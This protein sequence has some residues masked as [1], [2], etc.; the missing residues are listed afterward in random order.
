MQRSILKIKYILPVTLIFIFLMPGIGFPESFSIKLK[1]PLNIS[2]PNEEIRINSESLKVKKPGFE[3]DSF[4]IYENKKEIP[5][6]KIFSKDR[7]KY[8]IIFI[9]S[10]QP[11]ETKKIIFADNVKGGK[12]KKETQAYL[13]KKVDYILKNGNYS[14][15][16][17]VS[18][19]FTKVPVTHVEHDALYQF[20]GP[21]WESGKIAYR[22][23]LDDRNRTDIFGKKENGLFLNIIGKNDLVSDGNESYQKGM[24]DWGRDIFKVGNSLGIGSIATFYKNKV[25]TVSEVDSITCQIFNGNLISE[26]TTTHYG[27][28]LDKKYNI[29][30][31][32]SIPAKSRNTTVN[33]S[34]D[35]N[36]D[37]FCTGL[38]KHKDTD[39]LTSKGEGWNYIALWGKQTLTD[40]NLGIAVIYN[41]SYLLNISDD[42]LS[43]FVIL[44][45]DNNKLTYYFCAAWEQEPN[46]I[47]T[48]KGFIDYLNNEISKLNN[49]IKIEI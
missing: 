42:D 15:G 25:T 10:F 4:A 17:F 8:E 45:P 31:S 13:G 32:Y 43:Y 39:Y 24:L 40:D 26:I 49:P 11:N 3:F 2:R 30:T 47:K 22:V 37:N 38:A 23:Y 28:K 14:G 27:W 29:I 18:I 33:V 34:I 36:I 44:K 16:H 20:E 7:D 6:E 1:N 19:D 46:G 12:A 21:G 41:K 48:K 35:K 5:Y 9:L